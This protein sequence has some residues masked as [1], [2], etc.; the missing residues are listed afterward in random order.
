MFQRCF[1][2]FQFDI[3]AFT[4]TLCLY[5]FSRVRA[6]SILRV[7]FSGG[8]ILLHF[9]HLLDK[10]SASLLTL[11]LYQVIGSEFSHVARNLVLDFVVPTLT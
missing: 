3:P 4:I 2:F 10:F 5:L 7:M 9:T 6:F 11:H 8:S 1:T